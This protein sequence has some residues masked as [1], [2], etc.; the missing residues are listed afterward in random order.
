M[1]LLVLTPTSQYLTKT[2]KTHGNTIEDEVDYLLKLDQAAHDNGLL[3]DLKN[4][5][6]MIRSDQYRDLMVDAFDFS[7]IESCVS[8]VA[9][10]HMRAAQQLMSVDV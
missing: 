6:E 2:Q 10:W 4:S 8:A 3:I 5:A 1:R 7:V 9:D